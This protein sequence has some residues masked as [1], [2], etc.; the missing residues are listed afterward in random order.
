MENMMS[1]GRSVASRHSAA[2]E[3]ADR[4]PRPY[5]SSALYHDPRVLEP[6]EGQSL[7]EGDQSHDNAE[8]F[9]SGPIPEDNR[10]A[11]DVYPYSPDDVGSVPKSTVP[12]RKSIP[13]RASEIGHRVELP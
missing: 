9:G 8:S 6:A 1:K 4:L 12:K 7:N 10:I 13:R 5:D 3:L 2:Y 11:A